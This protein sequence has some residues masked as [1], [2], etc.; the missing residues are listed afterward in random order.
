M[1]LN[2]I[3]DGAGA[4]AR[5]DFKTVGNSVVA[6]RSLDRAPIPPRLQIA[7]RQSKGTGLP[8]RLAILPQQPSS[9]WRLPSLSSG[10][11]GRATTAIPIKLAQE[12]QEM[13]SL[14][15][16]RCYRN[17]RARQTHSVADFAPPSLVRSE[18]KPDRRFGGYI[19]L[20]LVLRL[21]N[22]ENLVSCN[23]VQHLSDTAWPTDFNIFDKLGTA[24]AKVHPIVTR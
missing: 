22:G 11:R 1:I 5:I 19:R 10:P 23:S 3:S 13:H 17:H 9:H 18:E 8:N 16:V 20:Q 4:S 6:E 14:S 12:L 7:R 24:Q 2:A 21:L 15:Q